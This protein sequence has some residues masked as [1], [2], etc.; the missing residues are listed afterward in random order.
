[1]S[2]TVQFNANLASPLILTPSN[3]TTIVVSVCGTAGAT[4]SGYIVF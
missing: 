2:A 4:I 1:L 3:N